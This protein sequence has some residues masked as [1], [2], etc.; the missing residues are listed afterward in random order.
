V[1]PGN[2][3]GAALG[4]DSGSTS[5][6]HNAGGDADGSGS[7][8]EGE[9][10]SCGAAGEKGGQLFR[11]LQEQMEMEGSDLEGLERLLLTGK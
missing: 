5:G 4:E 3:K 7:V 9:K 11:V 8:G 10:G 1:F 6:A 2:G